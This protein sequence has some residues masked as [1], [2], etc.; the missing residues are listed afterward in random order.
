MMCTSW[1]CFCPTGASVCR[2]FVV[3]KNGS[4]AVAVAVEEFSERF[5]E[6]FLLL[7]VCLSIAGMALCLVKWLVYHL[8]A[9]VSIDLRVRCCAVSQML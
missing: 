7:F 3:G 9:L 5:Y 4:C 2:V 6:G 8:C 1:H